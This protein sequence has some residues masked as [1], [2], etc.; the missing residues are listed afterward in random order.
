MRSDGFRPVRVVGRMRWLVAASAGALVG[1]AGLVAMA[2]A[3][4]AQVPACTGNS[5]I[6]NAPYTCTSTRT[7]DGTA[8]TIVLDVTADRAVTV[9]FSLDAP[10]S[11]PTPIRVESH[12]GI[13]GTPPAAG[14]AEGV[15]PPGATTAVLAVVLQC[16]QIDIKAVTMGNGQPAG[17]IA[18]PFVTTSGSCAPVPPSTTAPPAVPTTVSSPPTAA[19]TPTVAVE[20]AVALPR[21]GSGPS[22]W[23]LW[24]A[25]GGVALGAAGIALGARVRRPLADR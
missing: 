21:T 4:S 15:I 18:G 12:V 1:L 3:A 20:A 2:G 7:I 22:G 17:H 13:G 23:V 10:R 14:R 11:V 24:T 9:N 6:Q 25:L 8:F 16:G 5:V 19:T